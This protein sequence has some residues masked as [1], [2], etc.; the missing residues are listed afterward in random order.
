VLLEESASNPE[1]VVEDDVVSKSAG[2]DKV[3]AEE[4]VFIRVCC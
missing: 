2:D 1:K 4:K 3:F